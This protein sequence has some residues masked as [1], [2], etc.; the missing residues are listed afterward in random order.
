MLQQTLEE[1]AR[2]LEERH[3][4]VKNLS[5]RLPKGTRADRIGSAAST[6]NAQQNQGLTQQSTS[7]QELQATANE[8]HQ[9]SQV[10]ADKANTTMIAASSADEVSRGGAAALEQTLEWNAGHPERSGRDRAR[11]I[12][13]WISRTREIGT[14]SR[15]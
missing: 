15:P 4:I 5:E 6:S 7:V 9:T 12:I 10:A 11:R 8:I 14:T 2:R 1:H 13:A 3:G